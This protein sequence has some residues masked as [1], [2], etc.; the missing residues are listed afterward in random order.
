MRWIILL[1][2]WIELFTLIQLGG[3]IGALATLVYVFVTL[4][5]GLTI[6]RL[7]GMEILARLRE[8]Q[9][10]GFVAGGLLADDLAM[11]L[12]GLL[13]LIPGLVTDFAAILVFAGPLWRRLTG[14]TSRVDTSRPSP[15]SRSGPFD[16][17]PGTNRPGDPIDGEFRRLD[18]D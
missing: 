2:P 5:L 12:G 1:L 8:A 14:A 16:D 11:G 3:E 9:A 10:S 4:M 17:R 6:L 7:Q 18:D 15:F 13:L